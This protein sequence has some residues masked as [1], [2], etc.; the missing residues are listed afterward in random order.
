MAHATKKRGR[1]KDREREREDLEACEKV[2]PLGLALL[3]GAVKA[4][5][6][7]LRRDGFPKTLVTFGLNKALIELSSEEEEL[8]GLGRAPLW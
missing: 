1:K 7:H 5:T 8:S 6:K 2:L 4:L 3:W